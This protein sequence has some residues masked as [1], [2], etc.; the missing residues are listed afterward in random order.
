ML[1]EE[2]ETD[3][4]GIDNESAPY[5]SLDAFCKTRLIDN[6]QAESKMYLVEKVQDFVCEY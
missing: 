4:N 5:R 2:L 1:L 3:I 6:L